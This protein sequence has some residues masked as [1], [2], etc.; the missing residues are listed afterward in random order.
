MVLENIPSIEYAWKYLKIRKCYM[1]HF[2][3]NGIN[4]SFGKHTGYKLYKV[5]HKEGI[6]ECPKEMIINLIMPDA[7]FEIG[8]KLY[9]K[10]DFMLM[11]INKGLIISFIKESKKSLKIISISNPNKEPEER[12]KVKE[13][14]IND[15]IF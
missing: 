15:I 14:D 11:P 7:T 6:D 5:I 3:D 12:L 13:E 2:L 4:K 10:R 9:P 8:L 1:F